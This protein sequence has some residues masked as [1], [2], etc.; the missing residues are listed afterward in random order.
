MMQS[1]MMH[2][3][4]DV[5]IEVDATNREAAPIRPGSRF[6][7]SIRIINIGNRFL[8]WSEP[9][10]L[11]LSYRWLSEEGEV[12]ER[13]GRRTFLPVSRLVPGERHELE[14]LGET[15]DVAGICQLQVSLVLEGVHWACDVSPS[16]WST[17]SLRLS[18]AP[19]WPD[20]LRNSVGGRAMRGALVAS[21]LER[22]LNRHSFFTSEPAPS[23]VEQPELLTSSQTSPDIARNGRGA[24]RRKF[25]DWIRQALGVKSI[26]H[27][28]EDV[29]S[30]TDRQ[31]RVVRDLENQILL[32]RE[33][34]GL[35][36]DLSNKDSPELRATPK[37]LRL[38]EPGRQTRPSPP[39]SGAA[40]IHKDGPKAP[41]VVS[42]GRT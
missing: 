1:L 18:P 23:S 34:L 28:I 20:A 21:E 2:S 6:S 29:L 25:G 31:E 36:S 33:D 37:K 5:A 41:D 22:V 26:Q 17:V 4:A 30:A 10:P 16:G 11:T 8:E 35:Q 12:L 9:H 32:L 7:Y 19:A 15:P 3:L 14:L 13:D 38:S 27:Q 24:W 42:K 40:G 39:L